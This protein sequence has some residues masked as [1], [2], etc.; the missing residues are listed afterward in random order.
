LRRYSQGGQT[1]GWYDSALLD[2]D[3]F[4]MTAR[5]AKRREKIQNA[6]MFEQEMAGARGGDFALN[7][8]GRGG[9]G[10]GG[11]GGGRGGGRWGG[12]GGGTGFNRRSGRGGGPRPGG[13]NA[14]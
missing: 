1:D 2:E 13:T 12:R 14:A 3:G 4:G 11:R 10:A 9:G 8:G 7:G 5:E 6:R